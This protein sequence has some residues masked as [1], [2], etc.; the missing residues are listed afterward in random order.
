M[1]KY[2]FMEEIAEKTEELVKSLDSSVGIDNSKTNNV[3]DRVTLRNVQLRVLD[4]L[5][6]FLRY[7]YGPMG[8]NTMILH[9]ENADNLYAEYSKDGHKVLKNI[10]FASPIEM[11]IQDMMEEITRHVE[12]EV[13]DGTTSAVQLSAYIFAYL[14]AVMEQHSV[15]P[16]EIIRI[17]KSVVKDVQDEILKHKRDITL[18]DIFNICLTSTNGDSEIAAMISEIYKT[19]GMDVTIDCGISND[20]DYKV[21]VYDGCTL[22][23]GYADIGYVN[24][25]DNNTA[26]IHNP[27]IYAFEDPVDTPEMVSLF[28]KIVYKNIIEPAQEEDDLIPTVIFAPKFSRDLSGLFSSIIEL[29][30][31]YDRTGRTNQ[32]PPLLVVT[33]LLGADEGIYYDLAKL[34]GC[35]MIRKYIDPEIQKQDIESGRAATLDTVCEFYGTAELVVADKEKTKVINPSLMYEEDGSL[36]STYTMLLEFLEAELQ[37]SIENNDTVGVIHSLKKRIRSLKSNMVE[38]LVGGISIADRDEKRDLVVD[39]V[40][41]CASAAANGVGHAANFEGFCASKAVYDSY[42]EDLEELDDFDEIDVLKVE[43]AEVI[44]MAYKDTIQSLYETMFNSEIANMKIWESMDVGAPLNLYTME[45][46]GVLC[47]IMVD[48]K[49]LEAISK[50]IGIMVTSNQ[51]IVQAPGL[52]TY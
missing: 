23:E 7:T 16:Y 48:V 46:K 49:I 21:K 51:C 35:K 32:K 31:N 13:G 41:N 26:E 47:S 5:K 12:L 14:N 6:E 28:E 19:Y 3:V 34:C 9:G 27:R 11:A 15:P 44:F 36:S 29:L 17:F 20:S 1:K 24:R 39:A 52:N 30:Y 42:Q 50:L 22:S 10:K 25:K 4:K 45:H 38:L 18:D 43:I 33:N 2:M 37:S 8:S 40:K